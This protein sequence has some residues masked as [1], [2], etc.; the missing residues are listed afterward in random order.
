MN[1]VSAGAA[2]LRATMENLG[3]VCLGSLSNDVDSLIVSVCLFARLMSATMCFMLVVL[4]TR[5]SN[6]FANTGIAI[7][8]EKNNS[9]P[10]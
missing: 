2:T 8:M 3:I 7:P 5:H 6:I 10:N 9:V 1:A 4:R